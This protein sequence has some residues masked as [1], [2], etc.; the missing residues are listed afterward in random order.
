MSTEF[1]CSECS[2]ISHSATEEMYHSCPYCGFYAEGGTLVA[3]N[4]HLKHGQEKRTQLLVNS[5]SNR[6]TSKG[7]LTLQ[8]AIQ[9]HIATS[10]SFVNQT[11]SKGK[12][13]THQW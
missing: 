2:N 13:R 3:T 6:L 12:R 9:T 4:D 8:P 11:A 1:R 10:I 7:N 5:D